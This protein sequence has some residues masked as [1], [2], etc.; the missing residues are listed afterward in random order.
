MQFYFSC[1]PSQNSQAF[2]ENLTLDNI[3]LDPQPQPIPFPT[4]CEE[5]QELDKFNEMNAILTQNDIKIL[6][7][8]SDDHEPESNLKFLSKEIN[9]E[10]L[11]KDRAQ[12]ANLTSIDLKNPINVFPVDENDAKE[13]DNAFIEFKLTT[14][15]I[16]LATA[17][18]TCKIRITKYVTCEGGT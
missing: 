8:K 7:P 1:Q 12:V 10:N 16:F 17:C 2:S 6:L 11:R 18:Q 9:I 14:R 13:N 4:N 5:R 15:P 3:T